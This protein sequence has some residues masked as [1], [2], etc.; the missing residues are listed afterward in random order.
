MKKYLLLI[1]M[2][3]P[4][5]AKAADPE[6]KLS[7]PT[8]AGVNSEMSCK[9]EIKS[10]VK[11]KEVSA[12]YNFNSKFSFVSLTPASSFQATT[13]DKNGF[14]LKN[15]NGVNSSFALAT[16]KLKF[17][18]AGSL[19][20]SNIK[21]VDINDA[22]Y[23]ATSIEQPISALS[24]DNTLK[25]ITLS[26]GTLDP[27]FKSDVTS[28]KV[29]VDAESITIKLEPNDSKAVLKKS[30][31]QKLKYGLNNIKIEV[32]SEAGTKKTYTLAVTRLDNRSTNNSLKSLT[33]S[34]GNLKFDAS[35]D[36][37]KVNVPKDS[38]VVSINAELQDKD[39]E[40]VK[41]FGPRTIELVNE[42]TIAEVKVKS[43][44]EEI[45]TYT[46][47][48]L[49]TES[50]NTSIKE[51]YIDDY[52]VEL[53]ENVYNYDVKVVEDAKLA[54][55][56]TLEDEKARYEILNND[57]KDGKT[58]VIKVTAENGE[59]KDYNFNITKESKKTI[60]FSDFICSNNSYI[61]YLIVFLL[62]VILSLL[63][64]FLVYSRKMRKLED[65]YIGMLNQ[66][67][68][69]NNQNEETLF[70]GNSP[71]DANN[72]N[73]QNIPVNMNNQNYG[74]GNTEVLYYDNGNNNMN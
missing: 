24:T 36:T 62:G 33:V 71:T 70:Y 12:S 46:L 48:F 73:N 37:Y 11:I 21:I 67:G 23:T 1:I 9:I 32:K 29:E 68:Y 3:M 19:T 55:K 63:I 61:Y 16:L 6:F 7:C 49:K 22:I 69:Q 54:F 31:T 26:E 10:D 30:I 4:I 52:K 56:V 66:N 27:E 43:A 58:I 15:E 41:D 34:V 35:K 42:K 28:Y 47:T 8:G 20:L 60:F 44:T 59:T 39:A 64:C 18:S 45:K 50:D 13:S 65:K 57:L 40:F 51:L 2:I 38:T 17:L 14:V 53:M 74:D 25:S 5:L 72:Y